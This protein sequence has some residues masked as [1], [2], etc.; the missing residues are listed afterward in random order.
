MHE[1]VAIEEEK[2]S[3]FQG[4]TKQKSKELF[5]SERESLDGYSHSGVS[6]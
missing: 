5:F 6:L 4:Q 2:V 3:P 1:K